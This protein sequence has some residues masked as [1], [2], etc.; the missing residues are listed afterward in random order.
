MDTVRAG[1]FVTQHGEPQDERP[2]SPRSTTST[3]HATDAPSPSGTARIARSEIETN[4]RLSTRTGWRIP[5]YCTHSICLA[6]GGHSIRGRL[7]NP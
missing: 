3:V 2:G 4:A 5:P 6:A 7:S 1:R